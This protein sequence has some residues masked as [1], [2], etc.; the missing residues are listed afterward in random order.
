MADPASKV[1]FLLAV[2][3][4]DTT[5]AA[6]LPKV[7]LALQ[8]GAKYQVN[9]VT[10]H[11]ISM[12]QYYI[13]LGSRD[14]IAKQTS[15]SRNLRMTATGHRPCAHKAEPHQCYTKPPITA[16]KHL[17]QWLQRHII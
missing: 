9:L 12:H 16:S 6:S 14:F 2:K 7:T 10:G 11:I 5:E 3:H 4:A 15:L 13:V 1:C 17:P 8:V